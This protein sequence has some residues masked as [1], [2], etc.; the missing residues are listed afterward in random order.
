MADQT[1]IEWANATWN[2]SAGCTP[3]GPDCKNC[4]AIRIA[5]RLESM[6]QKKYNGVAIKNGI[7]GYAWTGKINVDEKS[8]EIP[9]RWSRPRVIFVNSMTDLFHE[10]TPEKFIDQVFAVASLCPRHV[11][12]ILTKRAREARNYM[13]R[14]NASRMIIVARELARGRGVKTMNLAAVQCWPPTNVRIGVS[15][16]NQQTAEKRLPYLRETKATSRFVS[17]EPALGPVEF[18]SLL[19]GVDQLIAGCESGPRRRRAETA[20]FDSARQQCAERGIAYF[21]KQ[22]EVA[23]R[24][25]H[26]VDRFPPSLQIRESTC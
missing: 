15:V 1:R 7:A 12:M 11:F 3:I 22:I 18:G 25:E 2:P 16:C 8:L 9:L 13:D 14:T 10:R 26:D 19:D 20:W 23:G 4:Y 24:V 17:Y 6:R 5:H 21:Q